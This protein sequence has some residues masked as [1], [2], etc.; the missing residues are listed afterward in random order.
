MARAICYRLQEET[1]GGLSASTGRLLRSLVNPGAEAP[2]QVKV[3][4]ALIRE[5][6]GV[7]D[8][9]LVVSGGL[10]WQGTTYDSLSTIAKKITGTSWNGPRFFGLRSKKMYDQQ[11][12]PITGRASVD[13]VAGTLSGRPEAVADDE[14]DGEVGPAHS[15]AEASE[16]GGLGCCGARGAKGRGQGECGSAKH[17]PDAEP[18][19]R[20]TG[21]GPHTRSRPHPALTLQPP[22]ARRTAT[23]HAD[24]SSARPTISR[25]ATREPDRLQRRR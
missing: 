19:S 10:C 17:G 11:E 23:G 7:V 25:A 9:V 12:D 21:A 18:G 20:V 24:R 16:Q 15:S 1:F 2:R 13:L 5:H 6:Q 14:P 4:S 22:V 8:E 3:G